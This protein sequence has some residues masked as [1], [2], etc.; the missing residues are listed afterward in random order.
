MKPTSALLL[1]CLAAPAALPARADDAAAKPKAPAAAAPKA[2]VA[3][4]AKRYLVVVSHSADD[5]LEALH[6]FE[7]K[8]QALFQKVEWGCADGVHSGWV[9]VEAPSAK[10]AIEKLPPGSRDGAKAVRVESFFTAADRK[11]LKHELDAE[12]A[13]QNED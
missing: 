5:C 7:H 11:N 13:L 1:V 12:R 10:A 4:P 6:A 8:E 2:A 9:H 3:K